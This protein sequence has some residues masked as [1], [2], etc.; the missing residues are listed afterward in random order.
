MFDTFQTVSKQAIA[1]ISHSY[2]HS[3]RYGYQHSYHHVYT[4]SYMLCSYSVSLFM[5]VRCDTNTYPFYHIL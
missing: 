2:C 1:Y 5:G 3:Y 4:Y